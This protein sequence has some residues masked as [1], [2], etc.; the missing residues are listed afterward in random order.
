[1]KLVNESDAT[2]VELG[3]NGSWV[4]VESESIILK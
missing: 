2:E 4:P 3:R 1:M